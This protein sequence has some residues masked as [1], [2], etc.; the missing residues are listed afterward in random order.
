MI[1]IKGIAV[2]LSVIT[3]LV[4]GLR[5]QV[6]LSEF[7]ASNRTS[8]L[9][10][11]HN[12]SDWL[13][14]H[15]TGDAMVS[16]GGAYL[17]DD[18]ENLT[19]WR[20]PAMT[21]K[22]HGFLIVFCS[23]K[24]RCIS[25]VELHTNF[26]IGRGPGDL[27]L[28][29]TDGRRI[30]SHLRYGRQT[31][32]VSAG[33]LAGSAA[34]GT[35]RF[36]LPFAH[37][38]PGGANPP[39]LRGVA[40]RPRIV[41]RIA[42]LDHP[43]QVRLSADVD[44]GR[45][46]AIH[47]TLDGT[48][49]TRDSP[50]ARG[51]IE[52]RGSTLLKAR[53]FQDGYVPSPVSLGS[54]VWRADALRG[55]SSNLP[56][57]VLSS[58]GSEIHER[59][60]TSGQL[61]LYQPGAAGRTGLT[62]RPEFS[63]RIGVKT[64]GSSTLHR[65]K[66]GY[67]LEL[68]DVEGEDRDA[69]LLGMPADSDW[70]LYG[71]F[72]FDHAHLR[73]VLAYQL[74]ESMGYYAPRTRFVEAFVNP[75]R[76]P[77][78]PEHYVGVYVLIEKI[79][80][81]SH[82]VAVSKQGGYILK[83]D[84]LGPA[85]KGLVA[86]GEELQFVYPKERRITDARRQRLMT[87]LTRFGT[88][89]NSKSA[90]VPAQGYARFIDVDSFID[91]HFFYEYARNP[92]AFSL[93]TYLHLRAIEGEAE[94]LR[95]HMGPVW[96]FDRAF[97]TNLDRSWVGYASDPEGWSGDCDYGWWG[98]L[99]QDPVFR[100]RYRSRGRRI[101]AAEL[102]VERVHARIDRLVEQLA[103][104]M[105]RNQ[106]RWPIV[107]PGTWR[108]DIAAMKRWIDRRSRWF[109]AELLEMPRHRI[110]R[111]EFPLSLELIND[112]S[113]GQLFYT[114]DGSDPLLRVGELSPQALHYQHKIILSGATRVKARVR[115]GAHFSRLMSEVVGTEAMPTV[116]VSE[117]MYNPIGGHEYEF[118]ELLNTGTASVDLAGITLRGEISFNFSLARVRTLE[119]G[120][121]VVV[122]FHPRK[123]AR[124][125]G[126]LGELVSGPYLG[127]LDNTEDTLTLH[128]RLGRL[129]GEI[130]YKDSWYPDTDGGGHSLVLVNFDPEKWTERNSW[131]SSLVKH[132]TPGGSDADFNNP[133]RPGK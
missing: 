42:V 115:V 24:N 4:G 79:S 41:P 110:S 10:S 116:A 125:Y 53:V 29:A 12:P 105:E 128:D 36:A 9:D 8:L 133:S 17:T 54:Y 3:C 102:S 88:A 101:L 123:F 100:A 43:A 92:D 108:N 50:R 59:S 114:L 122:M 21:I 28:V 32:G 71:P 49:P 23:G 18:L 127:R 117:I 119:P 111:T 14:L 121:R 129:I 22:A 85:E 31:S 63:C 93:S 78:S 99:F 60:K 124:R 64:R 52:I 38:T 91:Y 25:G 118:V 76:Q 86:A 131:R 120:G 35:S 83:I 66:K 74:V 94:A 7:M 109:A 84:R 89:L 26:R 58:F 130:K 82:R 126:Q 6:V 37:P 33:P 5:A 73:N 51:P 65:L 20:L 40:A 95:I 45:E 27:A 69:E 72:N 113:G 112:N 19:K 55:F 80:R 67:S 68:R 16:L 61:D 48:D 104:A 46:T 39:A 57:L 30:V 77:L 1:D 70:V 47:Y 132:G 106:R 103:E 15:N 87:F 62:G 90:A 34:T 98:R 2:T 96:D 107:A 97:R 13:E 56:L 11:D 44:P 75:T 81:G